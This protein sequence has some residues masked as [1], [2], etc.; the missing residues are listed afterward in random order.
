MD[1]EIIQGASELGYTFSG[2]IT[3]SA[4]RQLRNFG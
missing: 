4:V 1:I 2:L 3:Q